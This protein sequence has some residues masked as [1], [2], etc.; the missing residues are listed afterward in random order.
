VGIK[1]LGLMGM[2]RRDDIL[3]L[4][5]EMSED[6]SE[7]EHKASHSCYYCYAD[8][9]D[10]LRRIHEKERTACRSYI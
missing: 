1:T 5:K 6:S 7:Y 8:M 10:A 2:P 4:F 3:S 9:A